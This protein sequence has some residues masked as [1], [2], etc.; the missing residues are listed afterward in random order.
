MSSLII[1]A[2]ATKPVGITFE[3]NGTEYFIHPGIFYSYVIALFIIIFS[4]VVAYKVKRADPSKPPKGL[5][6]FGEYFVTSINNF[7]N[8]NL[9]EGK[10]SLAP[11]LGMLAMYI[12]ISNLSGLLSFVP[13]TSD[14]NVTLTLAI[15]TMVMAQIYGIKTNGIKKYFVSFTEPFIF[16]LPNN[17]L[18]LITTPLSMSL[19][20]FG[21]ILAGG[22]ILSLV[23]SALGYFSVVVTPL[24]HSYF[25]V[26]A[27]GIQTFV[28]V[29]LTA[30]TIEG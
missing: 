30:I 8:N 13:P 29:L 24:L 6:F 18:D 2:Q 1:L 26:F 7:T 25:D 3:I 12:L 14:Y 19:R 27:G 22:I 16:L 5:V 15:V 10:R 11:Y 9:S 17:I 20:L 28:F 4:M 21:N 23:Y